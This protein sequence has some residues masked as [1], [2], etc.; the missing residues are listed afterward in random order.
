MHPAALPAGEFSAEAGRAQARGEKRV[1]TPG[2][3]GEFGH[4]GKVAVALER[5]NIHEETP[6]DRPWRA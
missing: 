6:A 4:G 3:G 5:A 1:A 2:L